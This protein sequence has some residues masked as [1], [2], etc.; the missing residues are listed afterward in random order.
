MQATRED[1]GAMLQLQQIDLQ[2]MQAKKRLEELPQRAE[3]LDARTKRQQIEQK[4]AGVA[5]MR[6]EAEGKLSRIGDE[7]ARLAAQQKEKQAAIDGAKGGY[8]DIE[9]RS[10]ELN[11]IAKRRVALEGELGELSAQL[12]KIEGVQGQ[13]DAALAK[14][15]QQESRAI[16]SFRAEGGALQ[17]DIARLSAQR[18]DIAGRLPDDLAAA[19][20]KAAARCGGIA[21]GRLAGSA[22]SVCR[23]TLDQ[24]R[25]IDV[26]AQAPL[27][28]CPSCQ[29]LMV[30][31]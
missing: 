15:D 17:N 8:R 19:Y 31:E 6:A 22:C 30:V 5:E 18:A 21:V 9:A 3:I 29:R 24:T 7:D 20:T 4:G 26:R 11:G 28:T 10:K 25:L 14:L 16:E 27:A 13:I 2:L 23:S 12:E 1:L